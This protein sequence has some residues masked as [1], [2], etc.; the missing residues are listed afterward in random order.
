MPRLSLR[1]RK[2]GHLIES[3][4]RDR[5]AGFVHDPNVGS[6]NIDPGLNRCLIAVM[7]VE[8]PSFTLDFPDFEGTIFGQRFLPEFRRVRY[9]FLSDSIYRPLKDLRL[10]ASFQVQG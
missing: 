2:P 4:G 3:P 1:T 7:A 5:R 9:Q 6:G 10:S 8:K